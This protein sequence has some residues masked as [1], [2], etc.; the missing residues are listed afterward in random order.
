MCTK[1]DE[2]ACL[3]PT[4]AFLQGR[5]LAPTGRSAVFK[6]QRMT[7]K[8]CKFSDV[9]FRCKYPARNSPAFS[10]KE[11]INGDAAVRNRYRKRKKGVFANRESLGRFPW[12]ITFRRK[13]F[14]FP[15]NF[16][17]K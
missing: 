10:D 4:A 8:R 5:M 3:C 13:S 6:C 1:Q 14:S 15:P 2:K 11:K 12:E 17:L 9:D 7:A 16:L